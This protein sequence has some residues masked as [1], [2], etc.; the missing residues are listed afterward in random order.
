MFVV[1]TNIISELRKARAG[2]ANT[3]VTAWAKSVAAPAMF[4]SVISLHELEH[5]VLLVEHR[6]PAQGNLLR[7]WLDKGV[8]PA[9]ERRILDV[10]PE[11]ARLSA[12]F[13]LPNPAPFR[14]ALIAA[15]AAI[16][17]MAVVTHNTRDFE[18]FGVEI[19]DPW[20]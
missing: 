2:K 1:D 18:R 12:S 15:T 11:V 19:V 3:G 17:G 20:M 6:D 8:V 5:G 10:T 4:M 14:D 16:N 7:T 13:H 9:F